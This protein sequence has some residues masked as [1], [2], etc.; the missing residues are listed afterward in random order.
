MLLEF[1]KSFF[2][3]ESKPNKMKIILEETINM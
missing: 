2:S 3:L 1:Y